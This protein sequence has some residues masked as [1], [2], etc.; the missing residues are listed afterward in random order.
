MQRTKQDGPNE[1]IILNVFEIKKNSN[2]HHS[3]P[4]MLLIII[5]TTMMMMMLKSENPYVWMQC[6]S[7]HFLSLFIAFYFADSFVRSFFFARRIYYFILWSTWFDFF[8]HKYSIRIHRTDSDWIAFI[9]Y[10]CKLF[11]NKFYYIKKSNWYFPSQNRPKR[12]SIDSW[13]EVRSC[14]ML[15]EKQA[16]ETYVF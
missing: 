6:N 7:L 14:S 5:I 1:K 2:V 11:L 13:S 9:K 8:A 16:S 10:I 3:P 15:I 4:S 12:Y